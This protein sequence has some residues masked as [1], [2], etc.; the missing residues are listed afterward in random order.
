MFKRLKEIG[1]DLSS[2]YHAESLLEVEFRDAHDQIEDVLSKFSIAAKELV[3]GG[4]G[5]ADLTQRLRRALSELGWD[6]QNLLVE[7]RLLR[8]VGK[9]GSDNYEKQDEQTIQALSHE[10]D[11]VQAFERGT[12]LLEIEWNNKDPFFDR[13]LENFKRLHGDG[14]A[15]LG[16]ILTR[17]SS[18]QNNLVDIIDRYGRENELVSENAI[19]AHG[20]EPTKRQL[21]MYKRA[22]KRFDGDYAHGWAKSFVSDKYGTATTHWD[23]LID[24]VNRGVGNPCPLVAI[25]I[26][27]SI[28]TF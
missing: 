16:I 6:K 4:G 22:A 8:F 11:H 7:K 23:K 28:V 13:D 17:G 18:L 3:S 27:A 25:G 10:I 5:E 12:V 24:R 20:L 19:L 1:Y 21:D 9:L 15:S 14:A 26:P 2:T